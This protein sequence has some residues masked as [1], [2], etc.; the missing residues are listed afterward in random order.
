M[1]YYYLN[2]KTEELIV[3]D[4][5]EGEVFV[6]KSL[7]E[8][9]FEDNDKEPESKPQLRKEKEKKKSRSFGWK[10]TKLTPKIINRIKELKNLGIT[11]VKIMKELGIGR[12]TVYKYTREGD[13][14]KKTDKPE[15][16]SFPSE[17]S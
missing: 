3:V 9:E 5:E 10:K 14:K 6:I 17:D 13:N 11:D 7:D 15:F 2:L 4:V 16:K 12:S 1:K 8:I